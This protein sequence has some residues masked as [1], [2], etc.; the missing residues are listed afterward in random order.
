MCCR[1]TCQDR[2]RCE[3]NALSGSS[4]RACAPPSAALEGTARC[5]PPVLEWTSLQRE[6]SPG[7]QGPHCMA[8]R[9]VVSS[10]PCCCRG[11]PAAS[12]LRAAS[13]TA[14]FPAPTPPPRQKAGQQRMELAAVGRVFRFSRVARA[15]PHGPSCRLGA[16]AHVHV[17]AHDCEVICKCSRNITW[18]MKRITFTYH[19]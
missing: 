14:G 12:A 1:S 3:E 2:C 18:E 4:A 9:S 8:P 13:G 19:D 10:R 7:I 6:A 11:R 17:H 16:W 15:V 5:S